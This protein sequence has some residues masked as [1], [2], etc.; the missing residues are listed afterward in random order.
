MERLG[1]S[2]TASHCLKHPNMTPKIPFNLKQFFSIAQYHQSKTEVILPRNTAKRSQWVLSRALVLYELVDLRNVSKEDRPKA[3]KFQI[4]KKS[5]FGNTGFHV[6]WQK[7][8]AM[9]WFWNK[10]QCQK[11]IDEQAIEVFEVLPETILRAKTENDGLAILPTLD[12]GFDL[13]FWVKGVMLSSSWQANAPSEQ[14]LKLFLNG[15]TRVASFEFEYPNAI[16]S[17]IFNTSISRTKWSTD[18]NNTELFKGL[19]FEPAL[20]LLILTTSLGYIQWQVIANIK[21]NSALEETESSIE[22][23]FEQ[24]GPI[25]DARDKS[26]LYQQQ[27]EDTLQ[28]I[29]FPDQL[30]LMS[31]FGQLI[32]RKQGVLKEWRFSLNKLQLTIESKSNNALEYVNEIQVMPIVTSVSTEPAREKDQIKIIIELSS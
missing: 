11:A 30:K 12:D 20:A 18:K 16:Q 21:A 26:L 17:E 25:A 14:T 27:L 23:A 8:L 10:N 24:A 28:I 4:E 15:I 32:N 1:K 22:Q 13:Q 31:V 19:N 9:V 6:E 7:E 2:A 3:L 5:P 29:D